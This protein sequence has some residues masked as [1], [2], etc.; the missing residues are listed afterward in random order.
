V[1]LLLG[2][3]AAPLSW[4]DRALAWRDRLI[5]SDAFR[6]WAGRF[7]LTR[8]VTRKR[9]RALFDLCAGFVYS[10][11]LSAC[12]RLDLFTLLARGPQSTAAL[13]RQLQ[14]SEDAALRL[15][16]A[17]AS[18][19]LV[20]QR[21]GGRWGLG[22]LGAAMVGNE[23]LVA[24]VEHHTLLYADL[25]D[26]VRL[27]R[28]GSA[29]TRLS[30]FWPYATSADPAAV[31]AATA[32]AYSRVM[33]ASQALLAGEILDAFPLLGRVERLLDVGGGEGAFAEAAARRHPGLRIDLFDL[34]A[35]A[36]R[37]RQRF[38]SAG[39]GE[40]A[41]AVG[42]DFRHDPLPQGAEV[43]SLIRVMFDHDDDTAVSILTNV[44]RHLAP[45]ATLLVAEPM[46]G[47]PGAEAIGDA[48]FG[49]YLL[50]MGRGRSRTRAELQA[51]LHAAGFGRARPVAMPVP[52]HTGLLACRAD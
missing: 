17:A 13:A 21:S 15:L 24:M 44:R 31:D 34:P 26:P 2:M 37:A 46:A 38:A 30:A 27:L 36:D 32:A 5:G 39:L 3:D 8:P 35:V 42:G 20:A 14:L 16:R 43:V 41:R 29:G 52:L 48:Y 50:A 23:G 10:Q 11:V 45:G 1:S 49:F 6:R 25:A 47:T 33:A 19:D 7:P 9:A 40:R 51:L 22:Q 12:V 28:E 18:L 4:L